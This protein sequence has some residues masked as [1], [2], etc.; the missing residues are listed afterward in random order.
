MPRTSHTLEFEHEE[1]LYTV[2][3]DLVTWIEHHA[4]AYR[5]EPLSDIENL[6]VE[7]DGREVPYVKAL[8]AAALEAIDRVA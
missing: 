7:R 2:H 8:Y 6:V 4:G 1:I 5:G 3:Y